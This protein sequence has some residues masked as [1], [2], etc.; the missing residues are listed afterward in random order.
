MRASVSAGVRFLFMSIF[1][2]FWIW[3]CMSV[4]FVLVLVF[5]LVLGVRAAAGYSLIH[6][7]LN[8]GLKRIRWYGTCYVLHYCFLS[9]FDR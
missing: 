6:L 5:I 1:C 4:V 3:V 7:L 2:R 9:R 8:L